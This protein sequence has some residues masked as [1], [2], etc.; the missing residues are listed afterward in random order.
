MYVFG[1]MRLLLFVGYGVT[2]VPNIRY[3][4]DAKSVIRNREG[5]PANINVAPIE[6]YRPDNLMSKHF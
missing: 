1:T 2:Y 6:A 4:G 5:S 3:V